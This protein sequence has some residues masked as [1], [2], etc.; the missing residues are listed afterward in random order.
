MPK[1]K[2]KYEDIIRPQ[3]GDVKQYTDTGSGTPI[4]KYGDTIPAAQATQKDP[5]DLS[6]EEWYR[7]EMNDK[8]A[9]AARAYDITKAYQDQ[10]YASTMEAA[11]KARQQSII[12]AQNAYALGRPT[13]GSQAESLGRM[14]LSM[15]GMSDYL[16]GANYAASR[17]EV[18]NAWNTYAA[19]GAAASQAYGEGMLGAELSR[20]NMESNARS[21]Y[22]EA[23]AGLARENE[24]NKTNAQNSMAQ[25]QAKTE[26][27]ILEDY[28]VNRDAYTNEYIDALVAS[29]NL[30]QETGEA[31]K[32]TNASYAQQDRLTQMQKDR[33]L[34]QYDTVLS[35]I[36][37]YAD[38]KEAML[39]M[40]GSIQA[41]YDEDRITEDEYHTY[42]AKFA[43]AYAERADENDYKEVLASLDEWLESGK[44]SQ[45][46]YEQLKLQTKKLGFDNVG[47]GTVYYQGGSEYIDFGGKKIKV[48]AHPVSSKLDKALNDTYGKSGGQILY[49]DGKYYIKKDLGWWNVID[50]KDTET[51]KNALNGK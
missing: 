51:I 34:S 23:M 41:D 7:L 44:L 13:Y 28:Q 12:D 4:V 9:D 42:N 3:Y 26:A 24:V 30:T 25:Y 5:S 33:Y 20:L 16:E 1:P 40:I 27:A 21:T 35:R 2:D 29:G 50:D 47:K 48:N 45:K 8:M 49:K 32:A 46:D 14:G 10:T 37:E 39:S 11:R 15:S 38:G 43:N 36:D 31:M 17:Q 18:N 22:R 19:A 6:Y